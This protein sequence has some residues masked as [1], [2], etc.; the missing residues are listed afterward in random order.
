[1]GAYIHKSPTTPFLCLLIQEFLQSMIQHCRK[2]SLHVQQQ[3]QQQQQHQQQSHA[4]NKL[5]TSHQDPSFR[6]NSPCSV[7]VCM[8][9]QL[10]SSHRNGPLL[11]PRGPVYEDMGDQKSTAPLDKLMCYFLYSGL[12]TGVAHFGYLHDLEPTL[13]HWLQ[14]TAW[15]HCDHHPHN[16]ETSRAKGKTHRIC[17]LKLSQTVTSNGFEQPI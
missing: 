11:M 9:F 13:Q 6:L 3:Q 5:S 15:N 2:E 1:M 17:H 14:V 12:N 8:S 16:K 4:N 10:H 7:D